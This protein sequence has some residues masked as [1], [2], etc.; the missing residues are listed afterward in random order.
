MIKMYKIKWWEVLPHRNFK[1]M[2]KTNIKL[3][4]ESRL[5]KIKISEVAL[6]RNQAKTFF[7]L[8]KIKK[9]L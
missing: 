4:M 6:Y 2:K 3:I 9:I 7:K 8:I 5:L 1:L